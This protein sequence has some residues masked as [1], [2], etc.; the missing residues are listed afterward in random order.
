M[1]EQEIL[2][3]FKES[4][5]LLEGH[6]QLTSGRHSPQYFQ[7]AKVLQYLEYADAICSVIARRFAATEIDFV[8]APAIG[9]IVVAQE[10]GN[11]LSR[12]Q[13]GKRK[14]LRILFT[15]RKDGKMQLRRG[16]E[17]E[18]GERALVCE[19]VITTGGSVTE[20]IQIVEERGGIIAGVGA[21]VDRSG[22]K[23][24]FDNKLFAAV[25]MEVVS[26]APADCP[27]CK[28][29]IPIDAPGSRAQFS[30]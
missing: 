26:Y 17:I 29:S 7:C 14:R 27:L 24:N 21:I 4:E 16:F 20:V 8:I 11:Y 23:V 10:V 6:F 2:S 22:G 5:A 30:K 19:D 15:E 13:S 18:P 9:G 1:T 28:Q 25:T 12:M 3:I